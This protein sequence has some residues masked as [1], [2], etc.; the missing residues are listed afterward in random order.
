MCTW[1]SACSQLCTLH[2]NQPLNVVTDW[3]EAGRSLG[4][5]ATSLCCPSSSHWPTTFYLHRG[6]DAIPHALCD[7][8]L[9]LDIPSSKGTQIEAYFYNLHH[10]IVKQY[11]VMQT[12]TF[13]LLIWD[14]M[15]IRMIFTFNHYESYCFEHR[16]YPI[17]FYYYVTPGTVCLIRKQVY[18][19]HSLV[20]WK[21]KTQGP[22]QLHHF[23][24]SSEVR[25]EK[26][27][28]SQNEKAEGY[29]VPWWI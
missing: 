5:G 8:C 17:F 4:P 9:S 15:A 23:S 25:D 14:L 20:H 1:I 12:Y 26:E 10:F 22:L 13:Y 24:D 28:T 2:H 18:S 6:M 21:S 29:Q 19:I 16:F 11:S 3:E 27:I 7:Q